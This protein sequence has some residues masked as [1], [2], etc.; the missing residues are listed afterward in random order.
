MATTRIWC[1]WQD[2]D[3]AQS[4]ASEEHVRFKVVVDAVCGAVEQA[5]TE[6]GPNSWATHVLPW[7]P[8]VNNFLEIRNE[9]LAIEEVQHLVEALWQVVLHSSHDLEVQVRCGT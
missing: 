9:G 5:K 1:A 8:I 7:I 6:G 2:S 3:L 4:I